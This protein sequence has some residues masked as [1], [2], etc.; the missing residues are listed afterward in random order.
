MTSLPVRKILVASAWKNLED[1]YEGG[2]NTNETGRTVE[3]QQQSRQAIMKA[4]V[5]AGSLATERKEC[6][7]L[8]L[9]NKVSRTSRLM[10]HDYKY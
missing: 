10:E 9:G 1:G 3:L 7:V 8:Y 2:K 4:Q 5:Y 6:P